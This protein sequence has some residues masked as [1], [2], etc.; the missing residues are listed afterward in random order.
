MYLKHIF[1]YDCSSR[2][3]DIV[4]CERLGYTAGEKFDVRECNLLKRFILIV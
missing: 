2:E 3:V 1:I 4:H